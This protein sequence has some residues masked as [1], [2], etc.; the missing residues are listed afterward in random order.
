MAEEGNST[1]ANQRPAEAPLQV[2]NKAFCAVLGPGG[3]QRRE[4][5]SCRDFAD[6]LPESQLAWIDYVVDDLEQDL[7]ATATRLGF[8]EL[9]VRNL[10]KNP[11]SGYEDFDTE[12][13]LMIPAIFMQGFDVKIEPLF[14]LIRENIIVTLHTREVKRLFRMRRYA[15]T[16]MRKIPEGLPL[17]DKITLLLIRIIDENNSR[18]FD[19]LVEIEEHGDQLSRE[20]SDPKTPRSIIGPKIYEMKHAL[21]VYLGGL[22][23][24]VDTLSSLRYGDAELLTD[25][26]KIL[27]RINA[28][29][30]EVQAQIGLAE[31]LSEV[32]ASGLEVLQSIYNNQLQ[33]LNNKL[34]M[35]AAYLAIIG[36]A[37][38]VPNTIATIAGN[39]MFQFGPSAIP[40][41]LGFIVLSTAIATIFTFRVLKSRGL[42]PTDVE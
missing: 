17:P 5:Q 30:G 38:L 3:P 18:N 6:L 22:W 40:Y 10:L 23:G 37:L 15:E 34:A 20:L 13:G 25:D 31:H 36:T 24:T 21:I 27:D 35:L 12:L 29:T 39:P 9:L 33:I 26:E 19:Y 8:S 14:I 41:Y 1:S 11:R 28:L 16:L 7:I 42:L 32:L 2:E 4:S